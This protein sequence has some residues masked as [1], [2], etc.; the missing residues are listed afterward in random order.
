VWTMAGLKSRSSCS[1][2]LRQAGSN[3]SLH[4]ITVTCTKRM[5]PEK[6]YIEL[7]LYVAAVS[8]CS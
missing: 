3:S 6:N 5:R 4:C 1:S 7:A 2:R 8:L